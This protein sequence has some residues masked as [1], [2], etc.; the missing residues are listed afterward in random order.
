MKTNV[1]KCVCLVIILLIFVSCENETSFVSIK[2]IAL[3]KPYILINAGSQDS[4]KVTISPVDATNA[5]VTWVSSDTTIAKVNAKGIITGVAPGI[6]TI[7]ATTVDGKYTAACVVHTF[8]WKSYTTT[9]G[10]LTNNV[11]NCIAVDS[12]GSLWFGGGGG[13]TKLD[14]F[15]RTDYLYKLGVGDIVVDK[16][17][18]KWF[19]TFSYGVRK[20]DGVNWTTYDTS[21]SGLTD[22]SIMSA[23]VDSKGT[24]WFCTLNRET[25][26]STGVSGFD[27][28]TWKSYNSTDGLVYVNVMCIAGDKQDNKWFATN[29]G[30]SKFDG[31]TWTSYTKSNTN[32][33]GIENISSM[34]FDSQGNKWFGTYSYGLLKFDGTNWTTYNRYNSKIASN[35]TSAMAI[36]KQGNIWICT[37]EGGITKFDGTNWTKYAYDNNNN[38]VVYGIVIDTHGNKWL[39]TNNG[40]LELQD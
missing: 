14:E 27:G 13:V 29:K 40:V 30:L 23:G 22:N 15:G 9:N 25:F 21:N 20:F 3:T 1:L 5:T 17:N 18:N 2:G 12:L 6:S 16:Q 19:G 11:V 39:A 8:K 36:D 4:I 28:T 32:I 31:T 24:V 26:M 10:F 34:V 33:D 7:T 37:Y 38:Y 35:G